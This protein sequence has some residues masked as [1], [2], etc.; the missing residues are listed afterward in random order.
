MK[1]ILLAFGAV[2]MMAAG[3]SSCNKGATSN[4][5]AED[6]AFGDSVATALGEF[7]GAQSNTSYARM[8]EM[9][10]EAAAKFNKASFLKGVQA[11][12]NADTA[13]MAYFQGL[14]MGLQLA[15]PIIGIN[16]D[17]KVPVNKDKVLAA[18]KAVY[19]ADSVND[20]ST[21]YAQ[22]QAIMTQLQA[23]VKAR[24]DAAKAESPEAKKNLEEGQAY[25]EKMVSEGYTKAPSGIVYKIEN[26][27]T[28]PKVAANDNV[29]VQYTGKNINGEVFDTNK[30]NVRAMRANGFVPGFQE[31]L[32]M[33][34]KGG[35]M[36]V[37]IPADQAYGLDGAGDAIGPNQ[38]LVFDIEILDI[39]PAN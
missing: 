18:F 13:D 23:R 26:P 33:L 9:Q 6:K 34:G 21:Y 29:K 10:P 20:M 14:Q 16:N 35:K 19:E 4:A 12:L 22:Y 11:V 38:T 15:N 2:A 27:G 3:L 32:T 1:K 28:E 7:A 25:A 8:K 24:E 30:D 5:T 31:A 17:A 36:T 39:N 37:V